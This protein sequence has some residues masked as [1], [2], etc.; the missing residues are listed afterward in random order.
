MAENWEVDTTLQGALELLKSRINDWKFH[1]F[2]DIF[3]R[4]N[5]ALARL[6]GIQKALAINYSPNMYNLQKELR[7]EYERAT[8]QEELLRAQNARA[9][10]MT[11]GDRNSRLFHAAHKPKQHRRKISR[12]PAPLFFLP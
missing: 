11:Q 5:R 1:Y 8:T 12:L 6:A 9:I 3:K 10:W 2:G 7:E 4:K